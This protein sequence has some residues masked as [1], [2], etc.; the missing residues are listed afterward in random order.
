MA[1]A[2]LM[3]LSRETERG[4]VKLSAWLCCWWRITLILTA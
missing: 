1:T 4:D 3:N 2:W